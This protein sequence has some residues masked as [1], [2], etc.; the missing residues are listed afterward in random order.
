LTDNVVD[1]SLSFSQSEKQ[2]LALIVCTTYCLPF[3]KS[4]IP[5]GM[6]T[7]PRTHNRSDPGCIGSLV[8]NTILACVVVIAFI[9]VLRLG[10]DKSLE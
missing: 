9:L 3:W 1:I 6:K 4:M 8:Q 2:A 10:Y 5:V 7:V